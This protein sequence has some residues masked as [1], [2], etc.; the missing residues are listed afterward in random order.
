MRSIRAF[1][2]IAV[3]FIAVLII[4]FN[5]SSRSCVFGQDFAPQDAPGDLDTSFGNGGKVTTSFPGFPGAYGS[6]MAIQPD[7]KIVVVGE[8]DSSTGRDFAL[9]RYNTEGSLD[10]TF[11]EKGRVTTDFFGFGDYAS[12]VAIQPDGRI[13]VGGTCTTTANDTDFAL[14]RYNSDGRLDDAFGVGGKFNLDLGGNA[15]EHINSVLL[16]SDGRIVVVG[17]TLLNRSISGFNTAL[18]RFDQN[19]SLDATFGSGGKVISTLVNPHQAALT[20]VNELIIVAGST[21]LTASASSGDFGMVRFLPSGSLDTSFG[22]SGLVSTDFFGQRDDALGVSFQN[23]DKIIVT[24]IVAD[25]TGHNEFGVTRYTSA[26]VLDPTFGSGGK[27]TTNFGGTD[28]RAISAVPYTGGR[29]FVGGWTGQFTPSRKFALARYQ[30]DGTLDPSFGAAGKVVTEFASG[31]IDAL[32][33]IAVTPDARS[34]IAVGASSSSFAVARYVAFAPPAEFSLGFDPSSATGERGTT[35]RIRVL[36]NRTNG[37]TGNVTITPPDTSEIGVK[38]KPGATVSTSDDSINIK[39]KIK[40]HASQGPQQLV[41]KG[42]DDSGGSTSATLT[43]VI[44]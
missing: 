36:I 29:I 17:Q 13:V 1:R 15:D 44:Q 42:Q 35:V 8:A 19:G 40:G 43:L 39:F 9:A 20:D 30:S 32:S 11:G 24:G 28:E 7:G 22:N 25:G 41:F 34:L 3:L 16:Q 21:G 37:F 27:L 5:V 33:A 10:S 38:I 26:G 23:D 4:P 31:S 12:A 2:G 18:A 14:A 6:A